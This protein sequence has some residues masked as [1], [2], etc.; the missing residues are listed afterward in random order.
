MTTYTYIG[1]NA[2]VHTTQDTPEKLRVLID[3]FYMPQQYDEIGRPHRHLVDRNDPIRPKYQHILDA[4]AFDVVESN[5]G[6]LI[7]DDFELPDGTPDTL[8]RI[9]FKQQNVNDHNLTQL[10]VPVV[11]KEDGLANHVVDA[12]FTLL[13][14]LFEDDLIHATT[15]TVRDSADFQTAIRKNLILSEFIM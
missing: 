11:S 5:A 15:H 1:F 8:T 3:A 4:K 10:F 9:R 14:S 12:L 7:P 2:F 13:S 6:L